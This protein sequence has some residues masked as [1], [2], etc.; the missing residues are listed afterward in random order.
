MITNISYFMKQYLIRTIKYNINKR[1]MIK[2]EYQFIVDNLGDPV[3][4]FN[5]NQSIEFVN[6]TF[7]SLFHNPIMS[8]L[9][10]IDI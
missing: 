10:E 9:P 2:S 4:L 3:L 1:D 6:D 7:L 5:P 8:Q